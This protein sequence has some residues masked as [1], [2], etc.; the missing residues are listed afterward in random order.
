M[1]E[2]DELMI[3]A[4][5]FPEAQRLLAGEPSL[6]VGQISLGWH[7]TAADGTTGAAAVARSGGPYEE[8]IGEVLRVT[9]GPNEAF[10]LVVGR[11]AVAADLS[12]ARRAFFAL[13]PLSEETIDAVVE[14]V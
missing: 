14:I 3:A 4:R 10:V 11:A 12:L 2:P 13:A 7:D 5:A 8:L 9:Y 6:T 1:A